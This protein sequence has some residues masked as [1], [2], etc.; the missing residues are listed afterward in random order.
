MV[1]CGGETGE[2]KEEN[3]SVVD[4]SNGFSYIGI[5]DKRNNPMTLRNYVVVRTE[6][7]IQRS[8]E[9]ESFENRARVKY[10]SLKRSSGTLRIP[11]SVLVHML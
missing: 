7:L 9:D 10:N 2:R 5:A 3:L 1:Y 8:V 11:E 6:R 4:F